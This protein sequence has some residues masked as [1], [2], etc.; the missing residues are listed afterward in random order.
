[1]RIYDIIEKKRDGYELTDEE[2]EFF[3]GGYTNGV[4]EDYCASALL[5]AIFLNGM[6][7]RETATLTK[8]ICN[9]GDCV[10]LSVFGDNTVDKHSTGGVGD[11][12]TLIVAPIVASLGCKVAKMSGRGLGHTGG[13]VDK[14]ES[15]TGYKTSLSPEEFLKQVEQIGVC[16][17]GQSGNLAPADKKIYAL[18]DQTATVDNVS[19]IASSIMGK[20]LAAGAHSIV[21]DVKCGSGAFMKTEDGARRLAREMVEIGRR[22]GRNTVALVTDMDTPLGNC[23]GNRLEV[24]ESVKILKNEIKGELCDLCV[25]LSANMV[26][27]CKKTELSKARDMVKDTLESGKAF[28]KFLEWISCQGGDVE[29][30]LSDDFSKS[31]YSFDVVSQN[32]G[33]ISATDTEKIGKAACILGA[34][35]TELGG[36]IDFTAGIRLHKKRGDFVKKGEKLATLYSSVTDDFSLSQKTFLE[37]LTFSQEKPNDVSLIHGTVR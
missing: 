18:R 35:R 12:T 28:N 23:I 6:N 1:M 16:V 10:D 17:V 3:V 30:L 22:N 14:L 33:Y 26:S 5:M 8:A 36:K 9:S 13:T 29:F 2:I 37:A 4:I 31:E 7:S 20:K 11:K 32:D 34:G 25:E 21:L 19:L 15:I 27:L 24:E